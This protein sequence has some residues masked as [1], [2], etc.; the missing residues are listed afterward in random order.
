VVTNLPVPAPT[1]RASFPQLLSSRR[2]RRRD[3]LHRTTYVREMN[4][5]KRSRNFEKGGATA[6]LGDGVLAARRA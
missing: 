3:L 1:I 4:L 5:R 2:E 6:F